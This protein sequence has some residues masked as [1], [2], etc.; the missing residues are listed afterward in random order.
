MF[1]IPSLRGHN[2]IKS[3]LPA[4]VAEMTY[5]GMEV[6]NGTDAGVAWESM[7]RGGLDDV[8]SAKIKKALLDYCGQ[9]TLAPVRLVVELQRSH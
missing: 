4:L 9:D 3:V 8:E 1:T 5:E 2:S 7:V 6:A